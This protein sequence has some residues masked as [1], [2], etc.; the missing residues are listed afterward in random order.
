VIDPFLKF[1]A[2]VRPDGDCA[3]WT[4]SFRGREPSYGQ[5]RPAGRDSQ[6]YAHRWIYERTHGPIPEGLV[7]DHL[8]RRRHCV[9]VDHLEAVTTREN[10]LRGIGPTAKHARQTHCCHGH[11]FTPA[12]TQMDAGSRRCAE[13][14]RQRQAAY[15]RR[16]R[17]AA[18]EL[19]QAI[20]AEYAL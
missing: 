18:R 10:L 14:H 1:V 17:A 12:N 11:A 5:F 4:G 9:N 7:I 20:A 8:C 3:I 2:R 6:V 15:N 13:C 19:R 16:T